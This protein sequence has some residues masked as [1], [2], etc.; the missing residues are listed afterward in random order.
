MS[1]AHLG[2]AVVGKDFAHL[3]DH[4]VPVGFD[5]L[6]NR[7]GRV[8]L[9]AH[10]RDHLVALFGFDQGPGLPDIVGQRFLVYT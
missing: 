4:A 8:S 7:I 9:I 5:R 6:T 1:A 10:L 3:S 2:A